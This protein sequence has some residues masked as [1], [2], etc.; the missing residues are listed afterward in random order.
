MPYLSQT[1][2]YVCLLIIT[3]PH[4]V[5]NCYEIYISFFSGTQ[6]VHFLIISWPFFQNMESERGYRAPQ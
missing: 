2:F 6:K 3:H 1:C 5:R 4:V